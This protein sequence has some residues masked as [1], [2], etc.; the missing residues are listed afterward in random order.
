MVLLRMLYEIG[1]TTFSI[2]NSLMMKI[3]VNYRNI[4]IGDSNTIFTGD[5]PILDIMRIF[6]GIWRYSEV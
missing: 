1:S 3:A 5:S 4:G 6:Y 2:K